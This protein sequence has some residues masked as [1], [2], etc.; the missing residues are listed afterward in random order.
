MS[1]PE[2]EYNSEAED[3]MLQKNDELLEKMDKFAKK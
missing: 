2:E 3:Q 1:G